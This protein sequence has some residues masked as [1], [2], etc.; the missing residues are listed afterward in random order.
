MAYIPTKK[1]DFDARL[2]PL[3]PDY[4]HAPPD[5]RII[6]L[7]QTNALPTPIETKSLQATLSQTPNRIAEL[8]SLIDST[9]SLLR[10]LTNDRKQA[11]ENQ[12]NA[13]TIL[14]PCRRLPNE[15]LINI[16]IRCLSARDQLDSPSNPG[17]FHWTLSHVCRKWR[18]VAICTPEIWS[19][20]H[21]DFVHDWFL[22]GSRIHE[23]AFKLGVVLD[24]ARPH[25]LDV[26]ISLKD[27][28]STH[29]ICV[30]LLPTVRYWK[31]LKVYG[32]PDFLLPW[33]GFLDRLETVD[34]WCDELVGPQAVETF[35]VAPRL[36]SFK[37]SWDLPFLLPA[38]LVEFHDSHPFNENTCTILHHL[39]NIRSLSLLCSAYSS[40]LT[41][42][43]LPRVSQLR[44]KMNGQAV[45]TASL[46][47]N[48]F[49]LPSLTHLKI[50]AF[51][52]WEPI[53]SPQAH[54]PMRSSTVTHLTLTWLPISRYDSSVD[55]ALEHSYS[56]LTNL[57]CLTL[58]HWPMMDRFLGTLC[59]RPGRNVI[60]PKMSELD[61][62]CGSD[63]GVLLDMHILIELI[64]S[65][66]DQGALQEFKITWRGGVVNDDADTRS[67]WQQLCAPGG[68]IQISASIEGGV[69]FL[70]LLLLTER[71]AALD[72][73]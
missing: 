5:A 54:Q 72:A 22:T 51:P 1:S 10:Y 47:Y 23:A 21:L 4:S 11:L 66:R 16:F 63:H 31:S 28:I 15:L 32:N 61:V 12:V 27:D 8:D 25:D 53:V 70:I 29:P 58:E 36:C 9:A 68:G 26:F 2:A 62:F 52:S 57:R 38:N 14:S 45:D 73:N 37:K 48:H 19:R 7:L 3:L 41:R 17:A 18:E 71:F 59:I 56:T 43:C 60:F 24:R 39:V 30:V 13:K 46:T 33:R 6:D 40:E 20:I 50:C 69:T 67:Q 64:Q 35:A 55:L 42:I 65:R 34:V 49:D 44:L